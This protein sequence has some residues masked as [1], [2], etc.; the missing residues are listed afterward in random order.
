M[1]SRLMYLLKFPTPNQC[2]GELIPPSN[3]VQKSKETVKDCNEILLT[4][5]C[6]GHGA[7]AQSPVASNPCV[8]NFFTP[9]RIK[10]SQVISMGKGGPRTFNVC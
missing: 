10:R 1:G 7:Q 4:E 6:W 9:S 2:D 8:W 3:R 5:C